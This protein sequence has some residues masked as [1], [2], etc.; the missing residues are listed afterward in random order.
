[1]L[2]YTS[3]WNGSKLAQ[4]K[5][6]FVPNVS[7]YTGE[8]T[9]NSQSL[10][11]FL[12]RS[13]RKNSV[14]LFDKLSP[15]RPPEML[16]ILLIQLLHATFR[17]LTAAY[18]AHGITLYMLFY[19]YNYVSMSKWPKRTVHPYIKIYFKPTCSAICLNIFSVG[20]QFLFPYAEDSPQTSLG[21]FFSICPS[22]H[23]S[24]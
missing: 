7:L 15:L 12:W 6:W 24:L 2:T 14:I 20:C 9:I 18:S 11:F 4:S 5:R 16:Q 3:V 23:P 17:P 8:F 22:S 13:Q 21:A 19:Y 10:R 1:M